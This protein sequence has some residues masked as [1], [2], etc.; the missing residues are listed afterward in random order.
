MM[1]ET[2]ALAADGGIVRGVDGAYIPVDEGNRDYRDYLAWV[3]EGHTATPYAPPAVTLDDYA[4]D[5]RWAVETGGIVV[6]GAHIATDRASQ[7][8]I[9]GAYAY[10]QA[11]PSETISYKAVSGFVT[12]DAAQIAAIATAVG[13]H[14]QACFVAEAAIAAQI[15]SGEIT[16]PAQIDAWAWPSNS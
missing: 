9:A 10:S 13:A 8:M 12:L 1:S 15:V 3:G 16:T 2:Y 14:V 6:A 7:A 5:K 11:H 4:A